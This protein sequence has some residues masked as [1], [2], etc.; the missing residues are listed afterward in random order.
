MQGAAARQLE[1][2][3]PG[4][5]VAGLLA[6]VVASHLAEQRAGEQ[7]SQPLIPVPPTCPSHLALQQHTSALPTSTEYFCYQHVSFC[8]CSAGTMAPVLCPEVSGT[9]TPD[10]EK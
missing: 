4:S 9:G 2:Q 7:P 1:Q 3:E 8:S 5:A 6:C 10:K